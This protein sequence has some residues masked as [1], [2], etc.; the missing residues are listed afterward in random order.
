MKMMKSK[1]GVSPVIGVILMVAITVILA[2]IIAGVVLPMAGKIAITPTA[3]L[4]AS[5]CDPDANVQT[6][7][8]AHEGGDDL[9]LKDMKL[10]ISNASGSQELSQM[11]D[12]PGIYMVAG[13]KYKIDLDETTEEAIIEAIIGDDMDPGVDW[14]LRGDWSITGANNTL[15]D[16]VV[17]TIE[18]YDTETKGAVATFDYTC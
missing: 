3:R 1:E 12:T 4:K 9:E 14:E 2:A 15:F 5:D 6:F 11:H 8:L 18:V 10:T 16:G 17:Y 7:I 13:D